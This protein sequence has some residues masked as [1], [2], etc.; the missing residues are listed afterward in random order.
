MLIAGLVG[1]TLWLLLWAVWAGT[2]P[3]A[4]RRTYVDDGSSGAGYR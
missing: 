1:L 2:Y 3:L 4:R